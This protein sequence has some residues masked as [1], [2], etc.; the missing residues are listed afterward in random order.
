MRKR[1]ALSAKRDGE[2]LLAHAASPKLKADLARRVGEAWKS[3]SGMTKSSI[4][5]PNEKFLAT[6]L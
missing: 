3:R 6:Q 2:G 5:V 1:P 4:L